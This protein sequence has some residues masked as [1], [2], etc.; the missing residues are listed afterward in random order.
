MVDS[1][2]RVRPAASTVDGEEAHARGGAGRDDDE[3]RGVAVEH[4]DL[5]AVEISRRRRRTG[6][7]GD[8]ASSQRPLGL[9]EGEGGDGLARGDA[10]EVLGLGGVVAGVQQRVGGE[11]DGG[12]ERGAQQGAAHLLEHHDELD[13][14]VARATELLGDDQALQAHLLAHLRPHGGVVAGL[15]VHEL[16]DGRLA[17]LGVEEVLDDLAELFLFGERKVHGDSLLSSP[18]RR[19]RP[20]VPTRTHSRVSQ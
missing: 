12:E 20:C 16:T 6:G 17:G 14:A 13:V 3:V 5:G 2:V 18:G 1:A 4:V 10:R 8:A 15:G 7:G 9:G 19:N 11:H